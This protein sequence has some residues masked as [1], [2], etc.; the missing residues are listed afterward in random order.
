[1]SWWDV[2]PNPRLHSWRE[3]RRKRQRLRN[4]LGHRP[5]RTKQDHISGLGFRRRELAVRLPLTVAVERDLRPQLRRHHCRALPFREPLWLLVPLGR[6][7]HPPQLLE[8][9]GSQRRRRGE[10]KRRLF[11]RG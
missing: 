11:D 10:R 3:R 8:Q 6:R 7:K 1:R 9:H 2:E 4:E 5:R